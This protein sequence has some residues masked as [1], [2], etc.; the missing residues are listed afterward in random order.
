[1]T[2]KPGINI[3]ILKHMSPFMVLSNTNFQTWSI[4]YVLGP[5]WT[6][7]EVCTLKIQDVTAYNN[8]TSNLLKIKI[9]FWYFS[10]KE[11]EICCQ[12]ISNGLLGMILIWTTHTVQELH[13]NKRIWVDKMWWGGPNFVN[14]LHVQSAA[15]TTL[16]SSSIRGVQ[17]TAKKLKR[18]AWQKSYLSK[19]KVHKNCSHLDV[20]HDFD[21][22]KIRR[23]W[24][25]LLVEYIWRDQISNQIF[26]IPV[27][28]FYFVVGNV[29]CDKNNDICGKCPVWQN[30][31]FRISPAAGKVNLAK[32]TP[33]AGF[34]WFL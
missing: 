25:Q 15:M 7:T 19:R 31:V 18:R 17:T 10:Y 21:V 20:V 9:K 22:W 16:K 28:N 2:A 8:T 27:C 5:T 1:M 13:V 11:Q 23:I 4:T 3:L 24:S 26:Y 14:T 30:N 33:Q 12:V 32:N 6:A 29:L 34:C